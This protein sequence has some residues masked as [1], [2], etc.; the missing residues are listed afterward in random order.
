MAASDLIWQNGLKES[1][2]IKA[3]RMIISKDGAIYDLNGRRMNEKNLRP[4]IYIRNNQKII[5]R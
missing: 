2:A 4:G 1:T 5:I 3:I